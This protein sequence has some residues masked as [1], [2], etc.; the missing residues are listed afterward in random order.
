MFMK[1]G[2]E[3]PKKENK[4]LFSKCNEGKKKKKKNL[5]NSTFSEIWEF[6]LR[7]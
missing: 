6:N 2:K 3:R 7:F 1:I 4:K 5:S